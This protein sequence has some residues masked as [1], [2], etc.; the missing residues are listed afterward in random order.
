[1]ISE[2]FI[3]II[4]KDIE[5]CNHEIS[6]GNKTSRGELHKTLASKYGKII[7]GFNE[8]L[9]SL[10]YDDDGTYVK[11]NLE[12]MR[13]KLVLFKAMGF[14]NKYSLKVSDVTVNSTNQFAVNVNISFDEAK[15][16]IETM[17]S[18]RESEI[19][20]IILKINELEKIIN[21]SERK[22]KKWE[23]AKEIIKWA[24]DK[25][26]DVGITLLPLFLKIN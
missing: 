7:D 3:K 10:F 14:E 21:S 5:K 8:E 23:R 16:K 12:I 6:S 1:M 22:T 9:K 17:T 13:D 25:S 19:E 2:D 26:V 24:A 11:L 20:E 15:E 18:L 4:D